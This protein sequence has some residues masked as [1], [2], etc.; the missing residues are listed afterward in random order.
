MEKVTEQNGFILINKRVGV[1]SRSVDNVIQRL[2]HTR[3]VGHLGTLDPFASGLLVIAINKGCKS[4]PFLDDSFKTY[5]AILSLGQL[6][7]TGDLTGEIIQE[8]EVSNI[9]EERVIETL[10]SFIGVGEQIPPMTSALHH[11]GKRLYDLSRKGIEVER[12]PRKIEIKSLKLL[13][14]TDNL[15]KFEVTCSRGTYVRTLGEDIAIKLGTVGH[16]ISLK[17]ISIGQKMTLD[18]AKDIEDVEAIDLINPASLIELPSLEISD[19][20][21]INN[22]KSGKRITLKSNEERILLYTRSKANYDIIA[23]AVYQRD[24]DDYVILRGLW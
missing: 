9:N 19:E 5:Q 12:K 11:Q 20:Q 15:V 21:M 1:T 23:L 16:L 22:I 6:T 8:K 14:F 18:M 17:R 4:L 10:N 13:S 3:K 7:S 2:F 24:G